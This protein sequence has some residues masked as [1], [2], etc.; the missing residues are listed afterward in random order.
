MHRAPTAPTAVA[1]NIRDSILQGDVAPGTRL[2]EV[3]LGRALGVSRNTLREAFR[4]LAH[5]NLVEHRPHRGVFV[6]TTSPRQAS[7]IYAVRRMVQV[8]ALREFAAAVPATPGRPSVSAAAIAPVEAAVAA[9]EHARSV[10]DWRTVG[11]MNGTFHLALAALAENT[12]V[13]RVMAGLIAEMRLVFP[14]VGTPDEVH[15]RYLD[16]NRRILELVRSGELVR[17]AD[18]LDDYLV[19]TAAHLVVH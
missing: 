4:L 9:A 17:A 10:G 15:E 16:A 7:E 3:R 8:G 14:S 6:R 12:V 11:T 2:D 19:A 1:E 13:D 5:D 18:A